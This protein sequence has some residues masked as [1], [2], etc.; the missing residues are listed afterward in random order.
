M[1]VLQEMID[2][3]TAQIELK[4]LQID[5]VLEQQ[6]NAED[7]YNEMIGVM[8]QIHDEIFTDSTAYMLLEL[9]DR[10]IISWWKITYGDMY[11]GTG[12]GASGLTTTLNQW[13]V[14]SDVD[15]LDIGD[16]V[17]VLNPTYVSATT[18]TFLGNQT[19]NPQLANGTGYYFK[20]A[21]PVYEIPYGT[22]ASTV[23]N[24]PNTEVVF[25][26]T[27]GAI[28]AGVTDVSDLVMDP[29]SGITS[30]WDS[31]QANETEMESRFD[32][33]D[34]MIDY[35]HQEMGEQGTYGLKANKNIWDT[36]VTML[37]ADMVKLEET[38]T[39]LARF[40]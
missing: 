19:T 23:Y 26:M 7:Q 22:V 40:A 4:Q 2:D 24:A 39:Q 6:Q 32:E 16:G 30:I 28:P 8:V 11:T 1:G 5:N 25:T 31:S 15:I 20:D 21:S 33:F 37:Q 10:G 34:F 14:F 35:I 18:I 36:T 29:L 27:V 17:T 12:E 3:S 38:Q 9:A 13:Q